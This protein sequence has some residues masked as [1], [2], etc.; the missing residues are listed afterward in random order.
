MCLF[1]LSYLL[2][3]VEGACTGTCVIAN[4]Y[5]RFGTGSE[6]SIQTSGNLAQPWYYQSGS[7]YKL[8]FSSYPLDMAVGTGTGSSLWHGTT[9]QDVSALSP[10]NSDRSAKPG[11]DGGG[12][13]VE[14]SYLNI[15]SEHPNHCDA[16]ISYSYSDVQL[17]LAFVSCL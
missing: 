17:L 3:L 10:S 6:T 15:I 9:V 13:R 14:I 4:D 16:E 7:W 12:K 1:V 11:R 8:T 2:A 5:L